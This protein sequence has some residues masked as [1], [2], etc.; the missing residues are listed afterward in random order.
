MSVIVCW[1][2]KGKQLVI[3]KANGTFAQYDQKLQE[4]RSVVAPSNLFNHNSLPVS[5]ML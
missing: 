3:G 4:K 2:P 1:S 5:G